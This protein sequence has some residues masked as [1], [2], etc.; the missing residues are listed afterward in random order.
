MNIYKL[1]KLFSLTLIAVFAF[2]A[3][4]SIQAQ[5][6][7]SEK[8]LIDTAD[9]KQK[10]AEANKFYNE[11]LKI[12]K[13]GAKKKLYKKQ[14]KQAL[15][16]YSDIRKKLYKPA[17]MRI[18]L[19]DRISQYISGG[20]YSID[21]QFAENIVTVETTMLPP[22]LY[23]QAALTLR[24]ITTNDGLFL[25]PIIRLSK[26]N[27]KEY[28]KALFIPS[29]P[30]EENT[31]ASKKT[32]LSQN[33]QTLKKENF[34]RILNSP[35]AQKFYINIKLSNI[36]K[37]ITELGD[38]QSGADLYRLGNA[39]L[40]EMFYKR[41][42]EALTSY[43]KAQ[44]K[45]QSVTHPPQF[46]KALKYMESVEEAKKTSPAIRDRQRFVTST[47]QK[48]KELE[49]PADFDWENAG[50]LKKA[51]EDSLKFAALP[52]PEN[53]PEGKASWKAGRIVEKNIKKSR[54]LMF[55]EY[56]QLI[57]TSRHF[58]ILPISEEIISTFEKA[59][60]TDKE[61]THYHL[62]LGNIYRLLA[63]NVLRNQ[64]TE[65]NEHFI[66]TGLSFPKWTYSPKN[67]KEKIDLST[68][69]DL[70][71]SA[72]AEYK[73]VLRLSPELGERALGIFYLSLITVKPD[74]AQNALNHLNK[75]G[76]DE[77]T[78]LAKEYAGQLIERA[79]AEQRH[80]KFPK[81]LR[82]MSDRIKN[83]YDKIPE[84]SELKPF[85]KSIMS[86]RTFSEIFAY[87][88][89]KSAA[90]NS[91]YDKW[92][93]KLEDNKTFDSNNPYLSLLQGYLSQRKAMNLGFK[94]TLSAVGESFSLQARAVSDLKTF[95]LSG[96]RPSKENFD[97]YAL[98]KGKK[99]AEYYK[100]SYSGI[101]NLMVKRYNE[102]GLL[103]AAEIISGAAAKNPD[104]ALA[105]FYLGRTYSLL[106]VYYASQK[107]HIADKAAIN[108]YN[109]LA[110]D[111]FTQY[112]ILNESK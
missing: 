17:D 109:R 19:S 103:K 27:F 41:L 89:K 42:D 51:V 8:R 67:K 56:R 48:P 37:K 35:L 28:Q 14:F 30:T 81:E 36:R 77:N 21:S 57:Q 25:P 45:I 66:G 22:I 73:E 46:I 82:E 50:A 80:L 98:K 32:E 12:K 40:L 53:I 112:V 85:A 104:L 97:S 4:N 105:H 13:S 6:K 59:V 9:F 52:L 84:N 90:K 92:S 15:N 106:S 64:I 1:K 34:N 55:A 83:T 33:N 43:R 24:D 101:V 107:E 68:V 63:L 62:K 93:N 86:E 74:L 87:L 102:K 38:A 110:Q 70:L 78:L 49:L 72:F 16:I 3:A 95:D 23:R 69:N 99:L 94:A 58:N 71:N 44:E 26:D 100:R 76:A 11:G 54:S 31:D 88:T 10:L 60:E 91:T 20:M 65:A 79:A 111:T 108:K 5:G 96:E 47:G 18:G 61:N 7:G 2:S 75:A 29:S 39:M